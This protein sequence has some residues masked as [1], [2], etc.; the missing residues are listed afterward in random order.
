MTT[1]IWFLIL[2]LHVVIDLRLV[3]AVVTA[4]VASDG[5]YLAF[6]CSMQHSRVLFLVFLFANARRLAHSHN[7]MLGGTWNQIQD[8]SFMS[9]LC[10]QPL[11]N[12]GLPTS[13][14][15]LGQ[16]LTQKS[17]ATFTS[18]LAWVTISAVAK[19]N[20]RQKLIWSRKID[21]GHHF[22]RCVESIFFL[23]TLGL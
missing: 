11:Y 13:A 21:S 1:R 17:L 3:P 20:L 19:L 22:I 8:F 16:N 10:K 9:Q 23:E 6:H 2:H 14:F 18:Q 12:H 7:K 4:A 5:A 15:K